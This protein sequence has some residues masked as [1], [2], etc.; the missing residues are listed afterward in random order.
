MGLKETQVYMLGSGEHFPHV[1]NLQ[2]PEWSARNVDEIAAVID[3][4]VRRLPRTGT[5]AREAVGSSTAETLTLPSQRDLS[6]PS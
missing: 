4:A 6:H 2:R 5:V 1:E 3:T